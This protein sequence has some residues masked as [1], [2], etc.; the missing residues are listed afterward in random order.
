[1]NVKQY[2]RVTQWPRARTIRDLTSAHARA[3]LVATDWIHSDTQTA[4]DVTVRLFPFM[5]NDS[6]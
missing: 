2:H 1:M 4:L 3:D 5:A 6:C